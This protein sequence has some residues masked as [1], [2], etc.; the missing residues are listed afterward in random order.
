MIIIFTH[1][2]YT[3]D[4]TFEFCSAFRLLYFLWQR[5]PEYT[6]PTVW[7][8]MQL[9]GLC[10]MRENTVLRENFYVYSITFY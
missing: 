3:F 1:I 9:K 2:D 5:F 10:E 8:T 4:F 7:T 6:A